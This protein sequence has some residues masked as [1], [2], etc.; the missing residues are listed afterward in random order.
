MLGVAGDLRRC[1]T[2]LAQS[3]F[4]GDDELGRAKDAAGCWA[5]EVA[6]ATSR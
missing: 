2:V 6:F 1:F 4:V 5:Q 3:P